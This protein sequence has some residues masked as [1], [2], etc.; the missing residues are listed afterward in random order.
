MRPH[1]RNCLILCVLTLIVYAQTCSFGFVTIDDPSWIVNNSFVNSGV[2]S[3]NV[4]WAFSLNTVDEL[5]NWM[6]LTFLSLMID[7]QIFGMGGG[8]FHLTNVILHCVSALLLYAALVQ[9]TGAATKSAIVAALFAVHPLHVES[10]AWVTERKDVLSLCFGHAAIWAYAIYAT[11]SRKKYYLASVALFLCSLLSKQTLVTLP[12]LLLL[13]DYWPLRRTPA[14]ANAHNAASG[15]E[16]S[17]GVSWR[18]LVIEKIPFLIL[19]VLFCGLALFS[20]ANPMEFSEQFSMPHR[21]LNAVTSYTEYVGKMFWP[22]GLSVFYPH[23][24]ISPLA[25]IF[26]SVFLLLACV[27]AFLWRRRKPYVF[28]GWFWFLGTLIPVI[29][30]VQIG[31]QRM[32]DRYTYLPLT[33]LFLLVVWLVDDLVRGSTL[34]KWVLPLITVLSI[35]L[36]ALVAFRQTTLW[37]DNVA[38]YAHGLAA[39]EENGRMHQML[40]VALWERKDMQDALRH[41]EESARLMPHNHIVYAKWGSLLR[42]MGQTDEAIQKLMRAIE[43]NPRN[44]PAYFTLGR[45]WESR[46]SLDKARELYEATL[47]HD[48]GFESAYYNLGLIHLKEGRQPEA[49]ASFQRA[50]AINPRHAS[51]H[52]NLGVIYLFQ[53]K[54]GQAKFHFEEA[55]R[56]DPQLKQAKQGLEYMKSQTNG[57]E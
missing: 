3:T 25:G 22:A 44:A 53:Q 57:S 29:G 18:R 37:G 6:P 17:A 49:I 33:G 26:A 40:A 43:I 9:M 52:N 34:R 51:A 50:L 28:T 24:T 19:T 8:G 23:R 10:V 47:L 31:M 16:Q 1:L 4:R 54:F 48:P 42:E 27:L 32:A 15:E 20:Q 46:G 5:S 56:I 2:N 35:L 38:L 7:A 11:G 21:V 39:T 12:F 45:I 14:L 36:L 55:L 41:F 30:L 13:L